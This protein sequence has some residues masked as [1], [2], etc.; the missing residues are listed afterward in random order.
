[1]LEKPDNFGKMIKSLWQRWLTQAPM[2]WPVGGTMGFS[3]G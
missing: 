2:I 3:L 1:V